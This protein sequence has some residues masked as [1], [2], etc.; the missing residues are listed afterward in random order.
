MCICKQRC[1]NTCSLISQ[2]DVEQ[3]KKLWDN[4]KQQHKLKLATIKRNNMLTGNIKKPDDDYEDPDMENI[5]DDAVN[6]E[7]TSAIDS[8]KLPDSGFQ[9]MA[10]SKDNEYMIEEL[11]VG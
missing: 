4:S 5:L 10:N 6:I 2:R 8:D 1:G 7:I 11:S 9:T 3:L